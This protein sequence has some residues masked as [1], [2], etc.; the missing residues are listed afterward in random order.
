MTSK[1]CNSK[2]DKKKC[3]PKLTLSSVL[4]RPTSGYSAPNSISRDGSLIYCVYDICVL[5]NLTLEAE[6]FDNSNGTLVSKKQ[7]HGNT[8]DPTPGPYIIVDGGQAAPNFNKFSILDDNNEDT[9]R[10][11]IL[12]PE[13]NVT[14]TKLFADYFAEGFS[15]NGGSFS[16]DS[17]L[18]AVTYVYDPNVNQ[19]YQ[20]SILR[21]LETSGLNEVASYPY[22]GNTGNLTRFFTLKC[23]TSNG[24]YVNKQYLV[25]HS[26]GGTY[27]A[28]NPTSAPPSLLKILCL[29][30]GVISLVDE[31]EL[32]ENCTY[33]LHKCGNQIYL[34]VGTSRANIQG[35]IIVQ[36]EANPSFL[37]S[38]GDEYRVYKFDCCHGLQM[39][40]GK[41]FNTSLNVTFYPDGNS[42]V[43][44]QNI[45]R[46]C[47]GMFE[48]VQVDDLKCPRKCSS[49]I[50]KPG[51]RGFS[52]KFSDNGKWAIVT[53]AKEN[54]VMEDLQSTQLDLYDGLFNIQLYKV[55][56]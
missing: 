5:P 28:E 23:K 15:F 47:P 25:L 14:A 53:G 38:D 46:N 7:L 8:T 50:G 54:P 19:P 56:F 36:E 16:D 33:D 42:V 30:N 40:C 22:N 39:I 34:V 4:S 11:R 49:T 55:D 1:N 45:I 35:E 29:Q 3:C 43:I 17:G 9:A 10:L 41:N 20:K 37:Q 6:L 24:C 18:V 32:P 12:D 52:L 44:N 31:V 48:V 51:I 27:D 13:F 26:L 21:V 2:C